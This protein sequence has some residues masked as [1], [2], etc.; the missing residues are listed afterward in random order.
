MSTDEET[1]FTKVE[2]PMLFLDNIK[3][4]KIL[5]E[6]AKIEQEE[7][8]EYLKEIRK[9][10]KSPKQKKTLANMNM[11]FTGRNEAIK[12]IEGLG[13]MILKTKRKAKQG[14]GLKILTYTNGSK[15]TNSSCISKSR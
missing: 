12:I 2:N 10:S 3:T 9:K 7:L 1:D 4:G 8:N 6:E 13:S 11:L 14:T 5:I 15:I